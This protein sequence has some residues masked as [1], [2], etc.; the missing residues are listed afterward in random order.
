M[1]AMVEYSCTAGGQGSSLSSKGVVRP[2]V[3][4]PLHRVWHR[5]AARGAMPQLGGAQPDNVAWGGM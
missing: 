3:P 4:V 1:A 2:V 5:Q